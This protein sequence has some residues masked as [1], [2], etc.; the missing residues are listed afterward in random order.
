MF[1]V[2]CVLVFDVV[3][4]WDDYMPRHVREDEKK[5][6]IVDTS[7]NIIYFEFD[8]F[9]YIHAQLFFTHVSLSSV[10]WGSHTHAYTLGY[11]NTRET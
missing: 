10:T 1:V 11:T 8:F 7:L 4:G 3:D 5:E 9:S 2:L 6:G